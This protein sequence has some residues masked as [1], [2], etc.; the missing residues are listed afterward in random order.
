MPIGHQSY[1][2]QP[3]DECILL[4]IFNPTLLISSK[5]SPHSQIYRFLNFFKQ[6]GLKRHDQNNIGHVIVAKV[7]NTEMHT[8]N[9]ARRH[10]DVQL[11]STHYFSILC[12][13]LFPYFQR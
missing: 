8:C 10:S 11:L 3:F 1:H 4:I 9:L 6:K 7:Q 12:F 13:L 5:N 2:F